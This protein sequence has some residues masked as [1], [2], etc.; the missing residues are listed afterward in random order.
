M[1]SGIAVQY[2]VDLTQGRCGRKR[3]RERQKPKLPPGMPGRVPR[4]ARLMALAIR[5]ERLVEEGH[6]EDYAEI[7]R[8]GHVT[9]ARLTQIM[10][11]LNLAPDIQ[12]KIL[13]LPCVT[14]GRDPITERQLRPIASQPDWSEQ[15]RLWQ[16]RTSKGQE[17][18][19]P[20]WNPPRVIRPRIC[21]GSDWGT[22]T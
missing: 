22:T 6:V 2:E 17:S 8:F 15:R 14:R 16:E 19:G 5:F 11:L 4:V 12:E 20:N 1:T 21:G 9:R 13:F 7:A 18:A 10:N 3:L